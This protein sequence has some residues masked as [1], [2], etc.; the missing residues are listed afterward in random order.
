MFSPRYTVTDTLI[1]RIRRISELMTEMRHHKLPP[2]VL[3]R[4]ERDAKS[5]SSWSSTSIEGNPLPLTDVK[6]ILK[7]NPKHVRD[8][9][10]EVLNYNKALEWIVENVKSESAILNHSEI[11]NMQ[12]M[13]T[14]S[15]LPPSHI[16]SY[17]GKPVF[18]NDPKKRKT[19]YWPPDADD[20]KSL[21][22]ELIGWMKSC[23]KTVDQIITAGI[24]HRQFVL[25]H[26]FLDG[27]GRTARLLTT[28]L[29]AR[30]GFDLFRLFSFE[31]YYNTNVGRYF[32]KVGTLGNYYDIADSI[33]FTEWLEYFAEGIVDELLR[34]KGQMEKMQ[35]ADIRLKKHHQSV[36]RYLQKHGSITDYEYS[37]ITD[38]AKA[39][40]VTDFRFLLDIKLIERKGR[41]KGTYYVIP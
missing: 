3:T 33:D 23:C 13:V 4:L 36:L 5:L 35:A 24:F 6:K 39:T 37:K 31:R 26:P 41:G 27:N 18:V 1:A 2:V 9:E 8:S 38:R 16:G 22:T 21:M 7:A 34:I 15:L 19:I 11:C 20:V 25:I 17:R 29:L 10:R 28:L 12:K 14:E 40:R 30:G 32:K